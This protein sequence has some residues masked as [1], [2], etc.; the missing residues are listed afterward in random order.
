MYV[1]DSAHSVADEGSGLPEESMNF[2]CM[3]YFCLDRE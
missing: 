2:D 3:Y 1:I